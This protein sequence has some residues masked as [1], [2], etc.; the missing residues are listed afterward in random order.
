MKPKQWSQQDRRRIEAESLVDWRTL[1]R[2]IAGQAIRKDS[3]ER[4]R[5]AVRK[6]KL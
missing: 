4:I 6:L 5:A 1:E 2:F 3:E